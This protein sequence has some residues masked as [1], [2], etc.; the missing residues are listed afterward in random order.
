MLISASMLFSLSVEH[1]SIA[2]YLPSGLLHRS[3]RLISAEPK[4]TS[5]PALLATMRRPVEDNFADASQASL[6]TAT[7][8]LLIFTVEALS[9]L[10]QSVTPLRMS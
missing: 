4:S 9:L 3:A 7:W 1:T 2:G 5:V 6:N 8:S 10:D